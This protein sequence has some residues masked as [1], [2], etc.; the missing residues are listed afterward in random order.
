M[1]LQRTIPKLLEKPDIMLGHDTTVGEVENVRE[2]K[3]IHI[4]MLEN[5]GGDHFFFTYAEEFGLSEKEGKAL[6]FYLRHK[7]KKELEEIRKFF[8]CIEE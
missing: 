1:L 7:S 5:L 6:D 8:P 2:L 3:K 4:Q